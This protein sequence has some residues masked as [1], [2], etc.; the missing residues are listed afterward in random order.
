MIKMTARALAG[1]TL[2]LVPMLGLTPAQA[3]SNPAVI[4]LSDGSM[5]IP[6]ATES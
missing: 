4:S 5:A 1:A 2:A 3:A 6:L